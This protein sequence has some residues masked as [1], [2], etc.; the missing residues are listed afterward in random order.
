MKGVVVVVSHV[1]GEEEEEEIGL[2]KTLLSLSSPYIF[3]FKMVFY[4][5]SYR[6]ASHKIEKK[7]VGKQKG[8]Q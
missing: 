1:A 8:R 4:S 6:V 2:T 7:K 3:L 5:L